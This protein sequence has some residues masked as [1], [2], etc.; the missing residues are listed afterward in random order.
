MALC[1]ICEDNQKHLLECDKLV[2]EGEIVL[3]NQVYDDIFCE[4]LKPKIEVARIIINRYRKRQK[5]LKKN[6]EKT[7]KKMQ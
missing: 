1:N 5:L 6:K 3:K 4:N 7:M 2:E